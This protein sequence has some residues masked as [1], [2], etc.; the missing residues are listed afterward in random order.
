MVDVSTAWEAITNGYN[1]QAYSGVVDFMEHQIKHY[2]GDYHGS[3][4]LISFVESFKQH[5][6]G[7]WE[8]SLR[9]HNVTVTFSGP[10]GPLSRTFWLYNEEAK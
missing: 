9:G 10:Y 3:R 6:G 7:I 8:T 5:S 2:A 4:S 1:L